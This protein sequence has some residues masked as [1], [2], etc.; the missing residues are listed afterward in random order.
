[1]VTVFKQNDTVEPN[2]S[3]L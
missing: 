1:M 2:W 3:K